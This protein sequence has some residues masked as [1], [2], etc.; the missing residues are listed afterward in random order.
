[1][2]NG[3]GP[4]Q[5]CGAPPDS[6]RAPAAP[7]PRGAMAGALPRSGTAPGSAKRGPPPRAGVPAK[8]LH[9][10][11]SGKIDVD[12]SDEDDVEQE[13]VIT[14]VLSRMQALVKRFADKARAHP[15]RRSVRRRAASL[16]TR[17]PPRATMHNDVQDLPALRRVW[18]RG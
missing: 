15:V 13:V 18:R 8:V 11:A 16:R 14:D 3:P 6:L 4:Q 12:A 17:A 9:H 7:Q 1:M 2:P 10:T 5:S